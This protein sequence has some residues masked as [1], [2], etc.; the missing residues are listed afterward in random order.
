[1]NNVMTPAYAVERFQK[2]FAGNTSEAETCAAQSVVCPQ[3]ACGQPNR[4]RLDSL[5]EFRFLI[6]EGS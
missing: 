5:K 4:A 3:T 2:W 6:R 1:M